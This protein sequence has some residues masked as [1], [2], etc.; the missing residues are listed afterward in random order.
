MKK[1]KKIVTCILAV[2]IVLSL[3][4]VVAQA[5][6]IGYTN[7]LTFSTA[8]EQKLFNSVSRH[9]YHNDS[10]MVVNCTHGGSMPGYVQRTNGSAV[11]GAQRYDYGMV[12][13]AVNVNQIYES[14]GEYATRF[15]KLY[16]VDNERIQCPAQSQL[17]TPVGDY[18]LYLAS[19]G[20]ALYARASW[21]P[22][23]Y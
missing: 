15:H 23:S 21:S 20:S 17:A 10:N 22:D 16:V 14:N 5:Q 3:G 13:S 11:T 6:D 18:Y 4:V 12:C 1:T 19:S 9:R 8:N 7:A 2:V